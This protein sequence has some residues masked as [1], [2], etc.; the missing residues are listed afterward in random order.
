MNKP[1]SQACENNKEPILEVLK[2]AFADCQQ[3]LEVGSGTGQHAVYMAQHLPHLI[4]QPTDQAV[5]L[6][7]IQVWCSEYTG[8]N[9]LIPV[10]LDVTRPWP[11]VSA[12]GLFTANTLHIMS[13]SIVEALFHGAGERI[14]PGGKFCIYGPFNDNGVYTSDS[15]AAFD[16][17]LRQRDPASGIRDLN[18]VLP[19]AEQHGFKLLHPHTMPANNL[20]LELQRC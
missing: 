6:P 16:R 7:G 5:Y 2:T 11:P 8:D 18:A 13:W 19:L 4:W 20:L 10:E 3:V 9:L 14:P 15:N 12:D 1:Y 17:H